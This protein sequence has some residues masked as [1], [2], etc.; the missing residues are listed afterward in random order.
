MILLLGSL[1]SLLVDSHGE[2]PLERSRLADLGHK[3]LLD[4]RRPAPG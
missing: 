2:N 4:Q 3:G 1:Q